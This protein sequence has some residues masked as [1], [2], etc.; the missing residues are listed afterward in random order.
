[1]KPGDWLN[2]E[3]M[4]MYMALLQ[5][6]FSELVWVPYPCLADSICVGQR[7]ANVIGSEGHLAVPERQEQQHGTIERG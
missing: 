3:C 2:D 6:S 5:V 1:M 7:S 4:N